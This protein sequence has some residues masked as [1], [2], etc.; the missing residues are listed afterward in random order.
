[1]LKLPANP[2]ASPDFGLWQRV[3]SIDDKPGQEPRKAGDG[4]RYEVRYRVKRAD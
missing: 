1:M 2:P 4:D 3:D